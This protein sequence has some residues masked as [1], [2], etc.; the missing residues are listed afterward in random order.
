[1]PTSCVML[2]HLCLPFPTRTQ[3][4]WLV[5]IITA[6]ITLLSFIKPSVNAYLLNSFAFYLLYMI[7][8]FLR[9]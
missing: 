1:M 5:A 3:F 2:T 9:K 8:S 4:R 7:W 6:V